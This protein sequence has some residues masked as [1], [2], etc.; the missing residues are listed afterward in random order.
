[1]LDETEQMTDDVELGSDTPSSTVQAT[2]DEMKTL[3]DVAPAVEAYQAQLDNAGRD[4]LDPI[5]QAILGVNLAHLA[6]SAKPV[7]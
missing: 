2:L 5:A 3:L 4:G 7:T 6:L 1:M